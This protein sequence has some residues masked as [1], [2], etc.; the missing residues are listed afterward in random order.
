L[1]FDGNS[2]VDVFVDKNATGKSSPFEAL[3]EIFRYIIEVERG[4]TELDSDCQLKYEIDDREIE[5]DWYTGAFTIN[6]NKRK[7][8]G[9]TPFPDYVLI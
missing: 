6:G 3:F 2:F 4:K 7:T 5:I 1:H 9:K 8:I